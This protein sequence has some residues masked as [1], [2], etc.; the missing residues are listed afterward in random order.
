[1]R[2]SYGFRNARGDISRS[3][4]TQPRPPPSRNDTGS[5]R[6]RSRP[7]PL[8]RGC[9]VPRL[10]PVLPLATARPRRLHLVTHVA[11]DPASGG[12]LLTPHPEAHGDFLDSSA[13]V[14]FACASVEH[15]SWLFTVKFGLMVGFETTRLR[16]PRAEGPVFQSGSLSRL[17]GLSLRPTPRDRPTPRGRCCLSALNRGLSAPSGRSLL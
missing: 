15:P 2:T 11:S 5:S 4:I 3:T 16:G 6:R 10:A 12:P 17:G 8:T 1:M 13:E 14:L 7:R 9:P